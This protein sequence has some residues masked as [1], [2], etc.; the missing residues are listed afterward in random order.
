M[1]LFNKTS[2]AKGSVLVFSLVIL[3]FSLV[4]ALS[5]AAISSTDRTASL[6]TEKSSR[7]F[8]VADSGVEVILY[9]I[10][11][12]N[13][14]LPG[15]EK[16]YTS[17]TNLVND[18]LTS[19]GSGADCENGEITGSTNTGTYVISFYAKDNNGDEYKLD[20][21]DCSNETAWR[22]KIIKIKSEGTSG[23]TTRAVE[24]GLSALCDPLIEIC[25]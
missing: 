14:P 22:T 8:Q 23:N 15:E 20:G 4:S 3:A 19:F 12:K 5:I 1:N 2:R 11:K 10:Y 17:L 7:S 9:A 24:V 25:L 6:A 13:D 16:T 21:D 18:N